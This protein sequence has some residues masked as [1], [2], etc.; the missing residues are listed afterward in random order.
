MM[1]ILTN[2]LVKIAKCLK[3][4]QSVREETN[5]N[6]DLQEMLQFWDKKGLVRCSF[7]SF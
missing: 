5:F 3:Q 4:K 6:I 2:R 1:D 7:S